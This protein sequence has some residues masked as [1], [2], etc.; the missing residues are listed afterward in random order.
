METESNLSTS[1][2][3]PVRSILAEHEDPYRELNLAE[4]GALTRCELNAGE[5]DIEL[6][7]PYPVAGITRPLVK[8]LKPK[9]EALKDVKEAFIRIRQDVPVVPARS[10]TEAIPGVRQVICVASGK[11]GVGKST[12]AVNLALALQV[13]GAR[14]GI[15]DA[16]IYGPSQALMLG[17]QGQRPETHDGKTFEPVIAHGLPVMSMAFLLTER[18]PTIWRGPMVSGAFTQMLRQTNWGELDYLVIDLPPGTG[19]IQ[20]TLS[21]QVPVNGAVVVTTPQDIAL[22]DARRGIEMFRRVD[23]PVIGVVENMSLHTCS[24]CGHTEHLFGE[25]GGD[26]IAAEYETQLLGALPLALSIRE[27]TDSGKPSV[28]SDPDGSVAQ[29]YREIARQVGARLALFARTQ[30]GHDLI[31]K[32]QGT[33]E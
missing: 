15:L 2:Q 29:L 18:S 23:V 10:G 21:Q 24:N 26:R 14:V 30:G 31:T 6:T 1:I 32:T 5:L 8:L 22:M 3:S 28:I 16:D 17:V 33:D 25:G 20:L 9:F 11:G 19:D 27:Q 4:S 7:F 13:E 12:T